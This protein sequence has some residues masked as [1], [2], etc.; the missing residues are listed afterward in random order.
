MKLTYPIIIAPNLCAG[1]QLEDGSYVTIEYSDRPGD[2]GTDRLKWTD[3][4]IRY[5][6]TV[7]R[8]GLPDVTSDDLQSGCGGGTLALG[9]Q[10]LLSFLSYFGECHSPNRL[11]DAEGFDL[12]PIELGEW[13]YLNHDELSSLGCMLE[14]NPDCIDEEVDRG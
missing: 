14:E 13:A 2:R 10:S 8:D 6:W 12:F 3:A 9:M 11:R 1:V 5:R 7:L 4:R